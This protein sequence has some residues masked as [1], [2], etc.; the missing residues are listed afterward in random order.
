MAAVVAT[1]TTTTT[2]LLN[3][4]T[5]TV[6]ME[7]RED[8]TRE[9]TTLVLPSKD[10]ALPRAAM[11]DKAAI[12]RSLDTAALL[13]NKAA[14]ATN[15]LRRSMEDMDRLKEDMDLLREDTTT[16]TSTVYPVRST[17]LQASINT[18][19]LL[20]LRLLRTQEPVHRHLLISLFRSAMVRRLAI[21]SNIQ[22]VR[23]S[24]RHY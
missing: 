10:T 14:T 5:T 20:S 8:T 9:D 7:D 2:I 6:V 3:P 15:S 18:A 21:R 4:A 19:I 16:I 13:L 22:T 23:E 24:E 17:R 12:L 1:D 11:E